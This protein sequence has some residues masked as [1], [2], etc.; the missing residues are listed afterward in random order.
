MRVFAAFG[1]VLFAL[2]LC[3]C[4]TLGGLALFPGERAT[5]FYNG[6]IYLDAAEPPV[7]ALVVRGKRVVGAGSERELRK[8]LRQGY[9]TVDLRGGVAVPGLTDAHGHI[10]GL[11]EALESV[12]LRGAASYE[13]VIERV[14]EE[15]QR[16]APGTWITGRGWD[17]S[18]WEVADFPHHE[19]LSKAVPDHPVLIRRV[20]GHA[21]L[22]NARA[23]EIAGL[24]FAGPLPEIEGGRIEVDG[25]G[26]PT[27]LMLDTAIGRVGRHVPA[28][29]RTAIRRRILRAQEALLEL[30]LVCVHDMGI[31]PATAEILEELDE[32]GRLD[33]RVVAYL[34]GNAGL[35]ADT[36]AR[37]PRPEDASPESRLRI[38][39]A[40][41]MLDGALGSRGAALLEDYT[42]APGERG[43]LRLQ[44]EAFVS[45]LR[46]LS[47]AG[48]QP[49]THAIGDRANRML[50]DAY[51]ELSRSEAD[52]ADFR[53]RI[54]HA[55][56][57]APGDWSRFARLGVVASM[58]PTH[59]TS[60][61]RWAEARLGSER[62]K[63]AYAWRRLVADPG[64]LAFGSDFPVESPDPLAG[65]YA[66]R[67]RMDD[68]GRPSGGWL[69][70]QTLSGVEAL[71]AFTRGPAFA[72][73]E[74]QGRGRLAV[75]YFA[76]LTVL[77]VDPILCDPEDLLEAS[78]LM[79]VI[80]GKIAFEGTSPN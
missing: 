10:A 38:V 43:L 17:Q 68:E 34:L 3:A 50:L 33:L 47:R 69:A 63:G 39:G 61:M 20:D 58:Q 28:A 26:V 74:E 77:S 73:H 71:A 53:P 52:F 42:D 64:T 79:T 70:D 14:R 60:D 22:A 76:D 54:E 25:R 66:A 15:A 57:V 46:T 35:D 45:H 4:Q 48:L 30:G 24:L 18:L 41:L 13:E 51:A 12:S 36:L 2:C 11:G 23:L 16:H 72:A 31:D 67:T 55:Q 44:Y 78:V 40:K 8:G 62:L 49:A 6:T 29:D 32:E 21:A 9:R 56:V 19:A 7:E 75:G 65:L 5:L 27:G 1:P 80:D 37:Y 59:A